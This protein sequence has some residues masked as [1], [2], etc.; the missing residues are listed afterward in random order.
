[1]DAAASRVWY[2][3]CPHQGKDSILSDAISRLHTIDV[4]KNALENKQQHSLGTQDETHAS[5]KAK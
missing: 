4:Y 2:H 3:I 5:H 1:M